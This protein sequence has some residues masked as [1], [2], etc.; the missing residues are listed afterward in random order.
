[1]DPETNEKYVPYCIE[2]SLGADRVALAFL[3]DAYDE[4]ILTDSKGKE[5]TRV[6]LRSTRLWRRL[7]Q[8]CFRSQKN[9]HR[10]LSRFMKNYPSILMWIMT[11]RAPLA[12][13]TGERMKSVLR[14][15]SVWTLTRR[16]IS[17]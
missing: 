16:K 9:W 10:Q 13:A 7:K 17:V 6:V 14:S 3:V 2:P 12:N 11:R 4:A 1:M 15:A 5:D 8:L